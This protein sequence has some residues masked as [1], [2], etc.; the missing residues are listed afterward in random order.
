MVQE[1]SIDILHAFDNTTNNAK[2]NMTAGHEQV[3]YF[4]FYLA[5]EL[6]ETGLQTPRPKS[7]HLPLSRLDQ[8]GA[9]FARRR[10]SAKF[11]DSVMHHDDRLSSTDTSLF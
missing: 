7:A 9:A 6:G 5:T 4:V 1:N 2:T 10:C 8:D 11:D 3:C